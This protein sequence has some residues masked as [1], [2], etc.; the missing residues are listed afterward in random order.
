LI[1][2]FADLRA[3]NGE[4]PAFALIRPRK[5]ARAYKGWADEDER[6][7]VPDHVV[8]QLKERGEPLGPER[9]SESRARPHD[10]RYDAALQRELVRE[11]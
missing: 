11:I 6:Y 4:S 5:I 8:S 9:G 3:K 10:A 1:K 7:A 2:L